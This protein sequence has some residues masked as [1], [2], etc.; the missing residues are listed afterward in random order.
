MK[1]LVKYEKEGI[2]EVVEAHAPGQAT[3]HFLKDHNIDIEEIDQDDVKII[4]YNEE[5]EK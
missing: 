2:E 5:D 4:P 3:C 1:Y